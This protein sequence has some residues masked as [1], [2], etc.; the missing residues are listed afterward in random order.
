MLT[1]KSNKVPLFLTNHYF[2]FFF[3][4]VVLLSLLYPW[5]VPLNQ[6]V[7]HPRVAIWWSPFLMHGKIL[8]RKGTMWIFWLSLIPL[9]VIP[10]RS[11]RMSDPSCKISFMDLTSSDERQRSSNGSGTK[12][13]QWTLV[14]R[15]KG[16]NV[17]TC[18]NYHDY[19]DSKA[20]AG[21]VKPKSTL[22]T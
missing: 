9:L 19:K 11:P 18:L 13:P 14:E 10:T 16:S 3:H 22:Q 8:S 2:Y 21:G 15:E 5:R 4:A 1:T 7:S 17:T 6:Y 20:T 12:W